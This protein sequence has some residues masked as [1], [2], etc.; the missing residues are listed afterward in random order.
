MSVMDEIVTLISTRGSEA[1]FGE[2]VSMAEH[3]L[4]AA[5]FAQVCGAAPPLVIASLLHDI[6]HLVDDVPDDLRDWVSDCTSH[7][8]RS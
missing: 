5:H 2:R 3:G 4:Q 1:Y 7:E 8:A 6:G